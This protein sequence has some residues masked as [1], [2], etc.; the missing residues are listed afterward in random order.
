MG[1]STINGPFS[2]VIL[3]YQRVFMIIP[4][5]GGWI[6]PTAWKRGVCHV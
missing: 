1:K 2:I 3:V 6:G 5:I 4:A